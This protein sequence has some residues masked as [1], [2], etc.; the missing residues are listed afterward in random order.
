MRYWVW[1][2]FV[3]DLSICF[4]LKIVL[5]LIKLVELVLGFVNCGCDWFWWS[6]F[7]FCVG[8]FFGKGI[9][10]G[11]KLF[12]GK[13]LGCKNG[14]FFIMFFGGVIGLLLGFMKCFIWFVC[15]IV[16]I[17]LFL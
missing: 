7:F 8:F 9:F 4:V 13:L 2:F 11:V 17:G 6:V 16:L 14:L 12:V 3:W 15:I 1:F 5:L 10:G